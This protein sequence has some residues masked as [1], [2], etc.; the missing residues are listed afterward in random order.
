MTVTESASPWLSDHTGKRHALQGEYVRLGR[1]MDNEIVIASTR[2]SREHA[3]IGFDK[4]R[5]WIEDVG[6]ANG[7]WINGERLT[8]RATLHEGDQ[9]VIGGVALVYH[10]PNATLRDPSLATIEVQEAAGLVRIDQRTVSL[11]PKE[12]ALFNY[13][14]A[15]RGK[16]CS[17]AEIAAAVWPEYKAGAADYQIENLMRRLRTSLEPDTDT[18][19]LIETVR[20]H[21][22]RFNASTGPD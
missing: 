5:V 14:Y 15:R 22:Y 19:V 1:A 13:L 2:A 9:L 6:S 16:V 3:R 8:Q 18:P 20:G 17:K 11:P 21:G 10:D 4:H 12:L 7:T